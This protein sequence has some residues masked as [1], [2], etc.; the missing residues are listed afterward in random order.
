[1]SNKRSIGKLEAKIAR[2]YVHQHLISRYRNNNPEEIK[3]TVF[4]GNTQEMNEIVLVTVG[5]E[6]TGEIPEYPRGLVVFD[7]NDTGYFNRVR[8]E[9]EVPLL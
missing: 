7:S 6:R 9:D 4:V 1:V 2:N 8:Y 3:E 5:E